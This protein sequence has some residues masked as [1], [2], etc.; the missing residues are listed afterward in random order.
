MTNNKR[1]IPYYSKQ[2][3]YPGSYYAHSANPKPERPVLKDDIEAEI[4]ILGCGFSG[5]STAIH[6]TETGHEV[7][8]LEGAQVGWGASGRNGG[9]IV[10]GLNASIQKIKKN[11]GAETADFAGGLVTRGGKIIRRLIADYDIQCDLK[12]KNFFAALTHQHLKDL[13]D[14]HKLWQKYGVTE[15]EMVGKD[16]V[17]QYVKTDAY[18]GG[19]IDHSG[20][21]IHPLNLA[22]GEAEAVEKN[23]GKIYENTL[24]VDIEYN[25]N[26]I[27]VISEFGTVKC[28]KAVICGNAYL[29]KVIP[30]LTD[31]VMPVSTQIIATEPLGDLADELIPSDICVEDV[32][33]ILD[34]YRLSA[35]KRMLFGGGTV[36]GGTDPTDIKGKIRPNMEK[37]FPELKDVNIDFAWSGNFALSFSRVPQMGKLHDR[38]YFAHGYSGH[39][40]TG[41]HLFG[42]IL[43][44]AINGDTEEF[45]RFSSIRWFPFPGGRMFRVPYSVVGSWWYG[46]KD[47]TGL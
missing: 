17:A 8:M 2:G 31:R 47:L 14:T 26:H 12:E 16:E 29:N 41:T 27:L 11:Y 28:Q 43:A 22:L 40:V 6:L 15:R 30:K 35:D 44:N 33:Y 46:F 34:Y 32:R 4:C 20:G 1:N 38:V 23:G 18:V 24:V 7:V 45:D 39:G 36:Y 9:Q 37:I 42:Q 5:L 13:E 25:D 19:M 21:H 3:K 10:N